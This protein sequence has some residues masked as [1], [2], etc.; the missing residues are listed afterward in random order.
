MSGAHDKVWIT[1][2]IDIARHW[3]QVHPFTR[4][5]HFVWDTE[6]SPTLNDQL[7][8]PSR[9]SSGRLLDGTYEHSPWIAERAL[10]M[11]VPSPPWRSSSRR[12]CRWCAT[13]GATRQLALIR[14]HPELAG[15]A[16]VS[17]TL[18]AESTNEQGKAGLTDCTPEEFAAH[19]AAQRRLQRP[20]RLALHPGGARA[21][22]QRPGRAEI[23][24]TFARRLGNPPGLRVSPSACAT[25]TASPRSG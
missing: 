18:T 7:N 23:I 19:P 4:P 11:R 16:M 5:P 15:K 8:A 17:K 1:R 3:K 9:P 21:A 10:A 25:S 6:R 14:A 2:R 20:L 22:R 13:P 24:A 12:W